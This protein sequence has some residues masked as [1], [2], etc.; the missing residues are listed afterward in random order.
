M[1]YVIWWKKF[2]KT[3]S[4][5]TIELHNL[6]C[7]FN[8][9]E[10][11]MYPKK[12]LFTKK[13]LSCVLSMS[14]LLSFPVSASVNVHKNNSSEKDTKSSKSSSQ[15]E[16]L[17]RGL[18]ATTTTTTSAGVFLSWRLDA[19][20]VTGYS[21][22]GLIG[23]NFNLYRDGKKI[24]TVEDSTNYFDNNGIATSKYYVRAV[25]NGKEVDKSSVVT[26]WEK[27]YYE[28]PLNKPVDGI[29]PKGVLFPDGE[30]YTYNASDMSVGDIDGDGKYEY[31]VKW[32]PS[33]AKDVSQRGY[34]GKTYI[35]CYKFDGTLLYRIDLGVN[36]RSGAHYTQ[37]MVYD[38]D[39]DG[40]AEIMMK[41]APGTKII[42]YN[43]NGKV[44][45][46]KYI[47][48]QKE[49]IKAGYSNKD[50]YRLSAQG[51]YDH[52]VNMFMNWDKQSEVVNGNWPKTIEECFGI[53]KKYSYPLSKDDA[54][55]LAD[56]FIDKY[57]PSRSGNNKLRQ[58]EGFILDG[59]EYLSVFNGL[60]GNEMD[61]V[62]YNP[63]R[64]DDGLMWGDYAMGRIEPGNR[65]DRFLAG[66]AYLDGKKPSAV[67]ARGYYTRATVG[68]YSWDGKNIKQ[69]WFADSG[70]TPMTNPFNDGPHGRD[71]LNSEYATLT[72]QG[73]HTLTI[74]DVDNDG[75]DEIVYGSATL[76]NNGKL[77]Y[78]SF[79]TLPGG[80]A[81]PGTNARLGHGDS[82]HVTDI[83]PNKKGLEIFMCHEGGIYAPYGSTLRNAKTGK[84]VFGNYSGKDTGRCMI[85]DIDPTKP[86]LE[87][88]SNGFW[89]A[90]GTPMNGTAPG[91]NANI[92]WAAD[93]TTQIVDGSR[94]TTPTI[95][96]WDYEDT[97]KS[98]PI[99]TAT[100]TY[101][102]NDTK[103]NPCLVA[104]VFGDWR[105]ELLLRKTD[106]SAI[107]I[108]FNTDVTNHKLYTLMQDRQYRTDVA[109]QN[110]GYN[111]PAYTSF[112]FGSDIDWSKVPIPKS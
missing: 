33:N 17:D 96:K 49:D 78:S 62:K 111:Q 16:K 103:G 52:V 109:R 1:I 24:A 80:S 26:P 51:Y 99:L 50:D 57:A 87:L 92:K 25:V 31:F 32:D 4:G 72:T 6:E 69:K 15:M 7:N 66:V 86:G 67:F 101:T 60:T 112:Y 46:E 18:V 61:T 79:D 89:Q 105:E 12:A 27:Q 54:K 19:K 83:D 5:D 56:Y 45:S 98:V 23:A 55:E 94:T 104:D 30:S 102:N 10:T 107:R 65:C 29:T 75:K 88:W 68:A 41:T 76:D 48:M 43:K 90:D 73:A 35:D 38:F 39:G 13:I 95:Q 44:S 22:T 28:L 42:K 84:V 47:T 21:A 110:D 40:K 8:K 91:T 71:G 106:S 93:M 36:I 34:T 108:Y 20:E 77:L 37:F 11:I 85:G 3:F 59:P 100:G 14:V 82:I 64:E 58:F 63:G 70:H 9:G 97:K 2:T 74:A 81:S 53:E